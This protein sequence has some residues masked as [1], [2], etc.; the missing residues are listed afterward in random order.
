M[1]IWNS[2]SNNEQAQV[3]LKEKL[4]RSVFGTNSAQGKSG[5]PKLYAV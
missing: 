5:A 4:N 3:P 2:E 1:G